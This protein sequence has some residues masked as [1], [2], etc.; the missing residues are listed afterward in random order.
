MVMQRMLGRE[1]VVL[2]R[3]L[4]RKGVLFPQEALGRKREGSL[5]S[6]CTGKKG[7][8]FSS[9]KRYWEERERVLFMKE[10]LGAEKVR[11]KYWQSGKN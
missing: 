3:K 5:P 10:V 7:R 1:A 6:R 11:M 2:G 9:H 8:G 4:E